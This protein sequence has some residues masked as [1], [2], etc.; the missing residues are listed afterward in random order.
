LKKKI[1]K[2]KFCLVNIAQLAPTA[3]IYSQN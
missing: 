1:K 2:V 3:G